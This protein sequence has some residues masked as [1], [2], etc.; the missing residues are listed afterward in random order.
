MSTD[1]VNRP[2]VD[3][4]GKV[5]NSDPFLPLP[6]FVCATTGIW[7]LNIAHTENPTLILE[8][9]CTWRSVALVYSNLCT[10]SGIG[11]PAYYPRYL[12]AMRCDAYYD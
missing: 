2:R 6:V 7:W 9:P 3:H 11:Q 8:V 10:K 5:P 12:E 1:I 4:E